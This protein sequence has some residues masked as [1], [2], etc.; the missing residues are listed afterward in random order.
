M[1]FKKYW[2][3]LKPGDIVDV[4]AP[5]SHCPPENLR[6]GCEWLE[7]LGLIPRV[8]PEIIVGDVFFASPLEMQLKHLKDALY[9]DSK[10]V[11]CVR[12]GYGSMR[13]IPYL[14]KLKPPKKPKLFMGFS[15]ITSL[16]IFLNQKWKW[17]TIHGR[18]VS[19]M[20]LDKMHTEDRNLTRNLIMG[21]GPE[22]L[23]FKNLKPLNAFALRDIKIKGEVLGGNLRIV[24]SSLGTDWQIHAK[25][26]IIFL[27]DVGERGYSVHRMLE[28]MIQAKLFDKNL[29]ALIFGQ[30]T[31]SEEKNGKNLI[32]DAL[33][34]IAQI[35]PYPVLEG[36]P[37]GH[38]DLNFPLPFN[39]S[40]ELFLGPGEATLKV[41]TGGRI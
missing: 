18:N 25:N 16:H 8:P 40:S 39:T 14:K 20:H 11:W 2:N 9:S 36:L 6:L 29:K 34:R 17:P 1:Y 32:P 35:L 28:Q 3:Y 33:K 26:K 22:V 38:G 19:Q 31:E 21:Q 15:D 37:C 23:E 27:E 7:S 24:Q 10:A 13:L 12:G 4:I 30:F 5:A 41:S